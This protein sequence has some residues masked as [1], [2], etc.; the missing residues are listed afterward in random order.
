MRWCGWLRSLLMAEQ[1]DLPRDLGALVVLRV[2]ALIETGDG[3]E[4][5]RLVDPAGCQV[6]AVAEYLRDL[7]AAGRSASTQRSYGMALLRWFRF[8]W[9]IQIPWDEA[10]GCRKLGHPMPP[11][12]THG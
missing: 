3:W 4:P 1:G 2:G 8:L 11:G 7:Q 5:Y 9:S 10:C 12:S 6:E